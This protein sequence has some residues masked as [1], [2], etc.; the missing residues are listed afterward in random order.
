MHPQSEQKQN[1][2]LILNRQVHYRYKHISKN[3]NI[4]KH[5][6]NIYMT[7]KQLNI[8]AIQDGYTLSIPQILKKN[9]KGGKKKE[10][11]KIESSIIKSKI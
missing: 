10:I 11:E 5:K 4:Q 3:E 2:N 6:T 8:N 7:I 9:A 1:G